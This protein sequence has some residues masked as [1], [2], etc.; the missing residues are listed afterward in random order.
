V[1]NVA[2]EAVVRRFFNEVLD[3]NDESV[4]PELF[5]DGA[6]R[7]F[8]GRPITYEAG[9]PS[10]EQADR[11]FST[12][13]HHLISDGDFVV[14]HLTHYVTY[15]QGMRYVSRLGRV[16]ASGK[17]VSWNAIAMFHLTGGKIDEEWVVRDELDVL[18]Q[19][20][21]VSLKSGG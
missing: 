19:L 18:S 4:M 3:G 5:V 13:L 12:T 14:A 17:S 6:P 2:N 9:R 16:D 7:H 10:I 15:G 8:P 21:E 20:G 1:A 11:T